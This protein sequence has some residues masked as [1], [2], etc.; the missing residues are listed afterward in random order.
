VHKNN[1]LRKIF[2]PMTES[3]RITQKV[4]YSLNIV[5]VIKCRKM[6]RVGYAARMGK[7][8]IQGVENF[9]QNYLKKLGN[10]GELGEIILK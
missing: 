8:K 7:M 10:L 5:S 2:G 6:T 9:G 4:K 1:V 3:N